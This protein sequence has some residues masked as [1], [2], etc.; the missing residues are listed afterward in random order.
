MALGLLLLNI[1]RKLTE[2]LNKLDRTFND[3]DYKE[4]A[5]RFALSPLVGKLFSRFR[6]HDVARCLYVYPPKVILMNGFIYVV[7]SLMRSEILRL[8]SRE[9][10]C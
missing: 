1:V 9:F 3:V 6:G 8:G 5:Y 7:L 2:S 4:S 10:V